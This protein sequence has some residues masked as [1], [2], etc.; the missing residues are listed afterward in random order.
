M[1]TPSLPPFEVTVRC[2]GPDE[3]TLDSRCPRK[4]T[5]TSQ[6][7]YDNLPEMVRRTGWQ[8]IEVDQLDDGVPPREL[9]YCRN[10]FMP[11]DDGDAFAFRDLRPEQYPFTVYAYRISDTEEKDPVWTTT[12]TGPGPLYVPPLSKQAGEEITVVIHW[13]DGTIERAD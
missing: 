8:F 12:V 5:V 7:N 13:G 11:L 4:M 6:G 3:S 2:D 10:H 1:S 9:V